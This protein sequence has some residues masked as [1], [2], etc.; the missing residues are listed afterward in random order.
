LNVTVAQF[1]LA[2]QLRHIDIKIHDVVEF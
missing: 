1:S 2:R